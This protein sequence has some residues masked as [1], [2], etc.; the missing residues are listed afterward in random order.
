MRAEIISVGDELLAGLVVNS[1]AAFI[2]EKLSGL[3]YA[4]RW[5]STVGDEEAD[6]TDALERATHRASLV[7]LTGGLGPTHDDITKKVVAQFFDSKIVFRSDVLAKIEERF[8]KMGREM[9]VSN[10]EQAEVPEKAE[11]IE[12]EIGTAFGFVFE[13]EDR[14]F[15]IL[16]GVPSEMRRMMEKSVL[17]RLRMVGG[18]GVS[19]CRLLRTVGIS[20]SEIYEKIGDFQQRFPNMKLAFLPQTPGVVVRLRIS[21]ES[22]KRCEEELARAEAFVREKVERFVFG[23]EDVSLEGVVASLLLEKKLTIGVAESCTGGLV[24]HKLTDVPGSS[25]Y[26]N[27]GVVA[28]SDEAKMEILG[29]PEETI[30]VHGAVSSETAVVMAEGVRQISGTDI[31]VSATGIAGPGGGTKTKPVG[32][33]Y[34]GYADKDRS[35]AEKHRF[36]KDRWWNKERSAVTALDLVRRVLLEYV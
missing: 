32:L 25:G 9:V 4:V 33:V 13:R 22:K 21:G 19:Q 5:I 23:V 24:S 27:R 6:L 20:E 28:Y 26:F 34:I 7:V 8:R 2:G 29:V 1:N 36:M 10:R 18:R 12:N 31:G 17:P 30:R 14:T 11:L 15:F 3:G 35:F 16:P